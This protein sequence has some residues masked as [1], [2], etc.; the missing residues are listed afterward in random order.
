MK[1]SVLIGVVAG[2]T[3]LILAGCTGS[4][5]TDTQSDGSEAT[6]DAAAGDTPYQKTLDCTG[7][8]VE[9][10]IP[11]DASVLKV[12]AVG[13]AGYK[14]GNG[15]GTGGAVVAEIPVQATWGTTLYAKVGC[16]GSSKYTRSGGSGG[17]PNGGHGGDGSD[18]YGGG[19]ST[20]L[21][22]DK[23][24]FS[25]I[26]VAGAGGGSDHLGDD[27]GGSVKGDGTGGD[28]NGSCSTTGGTQT[29]PGTAAS[30]HGTRGQDGEKGKGG[31]AGGD[32]FGDGGGGGG[33]Y[34]GG[35]GGCGA[36]TW[37]DSTYSSGAAGSSW[38]V[39]EATSYQYS[40]PNPVQESGSLG[41]SFLCNVA[42]GSTGPCPS[43]SAS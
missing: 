36:S 31:D 24:T 21:E 40:I 41:Y 37:H 10:P 16:Q 35:A 43:P 18:S 11:K 15:I 13:A 14:D 27:V 9:V 42:G 32:S 22:T 23:S 39:R 17:W 3:A 19:G 28:G 20:S 4:S 26:I 2:A 33:G 38:V 34:Y 5:T 12:S 30:T 29:A 8:V 7:A 1:S 6:E 25:P